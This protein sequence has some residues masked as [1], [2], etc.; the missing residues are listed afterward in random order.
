MYALQYFCMLCLF[1]L[2]QDVM[3]IG[4]LCYVSP[5]PWVPVATESEVESRS[6]VD[7]YAQRSCYGLLLL[8]L[9][10]GLDDDDVGSRLFSHGDFFVDDFV[11]PKRPNALL[12]LG[13][14]LCYQPSD[15]SLSTAG[16]SQTD[17]SGIPFRYH[18]C[19]D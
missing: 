10:N 13:P 18:C 8:S 3:I 1:V 6:A 5:K 14:N 17:L 15:A 16:D 11:S 9:T 7:R 19:I 12:S 2:V 4:L